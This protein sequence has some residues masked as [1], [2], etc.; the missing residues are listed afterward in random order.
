VKVLYLPSENPS[1]L[2]PAGGN[3]VQQIAFAFE[4]GSPA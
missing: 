4:R 2:L 3:E 1:L